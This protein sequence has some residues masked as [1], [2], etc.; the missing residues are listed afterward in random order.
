[1]ISDGKSQS[2]HGLLVTRHCSVTICQAKVTTEINKWMSDC[3][4]VSRDVSGKE[5]QR[6][7]HLLSYCFCCSCY[8]YLYSGITKRPQPRLRPLC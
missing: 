8:C 7:N 3:I 6:L 2:M 1:M 5:H 4:P